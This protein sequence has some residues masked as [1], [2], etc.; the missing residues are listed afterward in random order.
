MRMASSLM[1]SIGSQA[2]VQVGKPVPFLVVTGVPLASQ[3]TLGQAI[4]RSR[5]GYFGH[6]SAGKQQALAGALAVLWSY[7]HRLMLVPKRSFARAAHHHGALRYPGI[8]ASV[9]SWGTVDPQ[10]P[11]G[12]RRGHACTT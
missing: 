7:D 5:G 6:A 2:L 9:M 3:V 10:V 11:A 8:A 12:V 1:A 4:Q